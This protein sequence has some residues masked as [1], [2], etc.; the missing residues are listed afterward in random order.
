MP[1]VIDITGRRFGDLRVLWRAGKNGNGTTWRCRCLCGAKAIVPGYNLRHGLTK[2]CGCRRL[3]VGE[4]SLK[5]GRKVV[6]PT[7]GKRVR[8][9]SYTTW[10]SMRQRCQNKKKKNYSLYGGRGITVCDRWDSFENFIAD[11]GERPIGKTIDRFPN[12]NGNY[13][14]GNCRWA[15]PSEQ[16]VNQRPPA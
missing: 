16:R 7:S 3:A 9:R 2:S 14:P 13:E 6:D 8:D 12:M 1:A 15:T 11:M 10:C 5:H 4:R